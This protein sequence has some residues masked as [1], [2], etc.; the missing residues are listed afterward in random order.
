MSGNP[1]HQAGGW[2]PFGDDPPP[3]QPQPAAALKPARAPPPAPPG[4]RGAE[5]GDPF[6]AAGGLGDLLGDAVAAPPPPPPAYEAASNLPPPP[7]YEAAAAAPPA[8][9]EALDL[10][11]PPSYDELFAMT[12]SAGGGSSGGGGGSS[13]SGGGGAGP[14]PL[15]PARAPPAAPPGRPAAAAGAPSP[16]APARAPPPAPPRGGGGSSGGGGSGLAPSRPAPRPPPPAGAGPLTAANPF[17]VA[18]APASAD[19]IRSVPLGHGGGSSSASSSSSDAEEELFPRGG[20][21]GGPPAGAGGASPASDAVP[22]AAEGFGS[23]LAWSRPECRPLSVAARP[24]AERP[25]CAHVRLAPLRPKE[26]APLKRLAALGGSLFAAPAG[27]GGQLLQWALSGALAGGG[28]LPAGG[29]RAGGEDW[30]SAACAELAPRGAPADGDGA[31]RG[32][33]TCLAAHPPSGRLWAGAAD[34]RVHCWAVG[35]A[36]EAARWQHAWVAHSGKVKAMAASPEG[37]LFTAGGS[38]G[39]IRM[40]S[41]QGAPSPALPPRQARNLRKLQGGP[42]HGK[43]M[44]LAIS[45]G[46]RVLWSCGRETLSLWSAYNGQHLGTIAAAPEPSPAF[47]A[48]AF[49][50]PALGLALAANGLPSFDPA[51]ISAKTG[52]DERALDRARAAS[53]IPDE[54]EGEEAEDAAKEALKTVAKGVS[55]AG[56]FLGKLGKKLEAAALNAAAGSGLVAAG[57]AGSPRSGGGRDEAFSL[58]PAHSGGAGGG[59]GG[60]G[61][62]DK[63]ARW[64]SI[65]VLEPGPDGCVWVGYRRGLLEKYSELGQLLWS[66]PGFAPGVTSAAAVGRAMWIGGLDGRVWELDAATCEQARAW[67]AHAFPVAAV[68]AAATAGGQTPAAATLGRDGAVRAWP[69]A[70]PA[71][72]AVAA[73]RAAARGAGCLRDASLMVLATTWNVNEGRPGRAALIEWLGERSGAAQLVVVG[74]QELEMGTSSVAM[75]RIYAGLARSK[76]EAGTEKAQLWASEVAAC[77]DG[78]AGAW[79]R[80]GLRQMSGTLVVAF[81]RAE[82]ERHVGEV[83][84]SCVTCGVM[85]V[86]GNKGAVALSFSLMRRRVMVVASHFAAHQEK[87]ASRNADYAKIVRTL[88]FHNTPAS[89][90]AGSGDGAAAGGGADGG[91]GSGDGG[92]GGGGDDAWG[93]GLRDADLLIWVGDFNYRVDCP[94]GFAPVDETPENTRNDQLYGFVHDRISRRQHLQLLGGDQM[95]REAHRGAIFV[96]LGEGPI[97]FLPTYKFEKGRE[98]SERQ[99]FYDQGEKRRVPAWTDRVLFRGS[100]PQGS[101]LAPPEGGDPEDVKV[102]LAGGTA[103][104]YGSC[105]TVNDSDHKPVYCLLEVDLPAFEQEASR[106]AALAAIAGAARGGV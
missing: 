101:P 90:Q 25:L 7:P 103:A 97:T 60:G 99:P 70:A 1:F 11:P 45:A 26:A 22:R 83:S 73:W 63:A 21:P 16:L 29:Q 44:R 92:G 91:D 80:V 89:A 93:S 32:A 19:A 56:K 23:A 40:W 67:R 106:R 49:A 82:L 85:G 84:T 3:P 62:A 66:S 54:G 78:G 6:A 59:G 5:P 53:F 34:G 77:L 64:G 72:A 28:T 10:P 46:G 15:K 27:E 86:G 98:S 88:R 31:A 105:M 55:K 102:A 57:S 24:A 65:K 43:V 74:L 69:A 4:A 20:R 71:A 8:Y 36:G 61:A 68:A 42:P 104:S 100:A 18:G 51:A 13:G 9:G 2:D 35:A 75:D 48:A 81:V 52:L 38:A 94:P 37:R 87:V 50:S 12:A 30:D 76:L 14:S 39:A 58:S 17:A 33:V 79:R 95:L 47:G 96:G 41:Y